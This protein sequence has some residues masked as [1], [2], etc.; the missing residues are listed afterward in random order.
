[1]SPFP[2]VNELR[3]KFAEAKYIFEE[4][5]IRQVYVAGVMQN[6][7]L[8]EGPLRGGNQWTNCSVTADVALATDLDASWA[9]PI[10]VVPRDGSE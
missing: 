1:M 5:T 3:A 6:P 2:S 10:V 9:V 7:I 8:I 4:D